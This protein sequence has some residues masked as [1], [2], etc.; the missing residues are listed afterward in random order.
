MEFHVDCSYAARILR[1]ASLVLDIV[2]VI[3]RGDKPDGLML[4]RLMNLF[5][6]RW[7]EQ[8]AE[9]GG[10]AAAAAPGIRNESAK[11]V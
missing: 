1:L 3:P 8:R 7:D 11:Q 5:S 6:A 10:S 9:S 4:G 2:E